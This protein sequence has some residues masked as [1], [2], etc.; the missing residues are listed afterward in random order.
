V[1]VVTHF[2]PGRPR[3]P[4]RL[5]FY[6]QLEGRQSTVARRLPRRTQRPSDP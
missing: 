3:R 1:I 2:G 6:L 4:V 5:V